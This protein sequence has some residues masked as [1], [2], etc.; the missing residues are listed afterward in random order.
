M[1]DSPRSNASTIF[2]KAS[3]NQVNN[4]LRRELGSLIQTI[5]GP[6]RCRI[7]RRAKSSSFETIPAPALSA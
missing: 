4:S 6:F 7:L 2:G 3:A 5:D 1:N